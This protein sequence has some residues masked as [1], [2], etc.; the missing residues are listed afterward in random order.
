MRLVS[1]AAMAMILFVAAASSAQVAARLVPSRT[2]GV[3]PLSVFLDG[4]TSSACRASCYADSIGYGRVA[5][6][7]AGQHARW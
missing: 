5:A 7:L 4:S 2:S 1:M 6:T 3:A